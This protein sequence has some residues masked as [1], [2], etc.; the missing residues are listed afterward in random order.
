M[1]EDTD[2]DYFYKRMHRCVRCGSNLTP[3]ERAKEAIMCTTCRARLKRS[4]EKPQLSPAIQSKLEKCRQCTFSTDRGDGV[5]FCPSAAGTCI[6]E[7]MEKRER[8]LHGNGN[9]AGGGDDAGDDGVPVG[10]EG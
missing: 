8:I 2:M 6:R 4:T 7:E 10:G 3:A 1:M 5:L 9:P